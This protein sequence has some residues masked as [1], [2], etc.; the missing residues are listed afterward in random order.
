MKKPPKTVSLHLDE[1]LDDSPRQATSMSLPV[2]VSYKL[3]FLAELAKTLRTS[4]GEL[5]SMLIDAAPEKAEDLERALLAYR[6]KTVRD[7]LPA[8]PDRPSEDENVI[9]LP[10]RHPGRPSRKSAG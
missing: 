4:R 8:R 3:D 10:V 7:A 6:R 1:S 9:D 5:I 2:A